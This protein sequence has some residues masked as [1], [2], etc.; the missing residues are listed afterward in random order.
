MK[1]RER[2]FKK[3]SSYNSVSV[4]R[5]KVNSYLLSQYNISDAW[6]CDYYLPHRE[7]SYDKILD[8]V[9]FGDFLRKFLQGGLWPFDQYRFWVLSEAS[10]K[11]MTDFI[12]IPKD[13]V[14]VI[15]RYE[16]FSKGDLKEPFNLKKIKKIYSVGQLRSEKN[17]F[18]SLWLVYFL[19]QEHHLQIEF[20]IVGDFYLG[21][22]YAEDDR[23]IFKE[24]VLSLINDLDWKIKPIFHGPIENFSWEKSSNDYAFLNLSTYF[25]EDF[26]L[27]QASSQEHNW[28]SIVSQW[29]GLLD[30]EGD[31][32]AQIPFQIIGNSGD[33]ILVSKIRGKTLAHYLINE[34]NEKIVIQ[35]SIAKMPSP[36]TDSEL[37]VIRKKFIK[38]WGPSVYHV[39]N[40]INLVLD[41][42]KGVS[43]HESYQEIFSQSKNEFKKVVMINELDD[44][45]NDMPDRVSK[46]KIDHE[47]SLIQ[48]KD[49]RFKEILNKS[50]SAKEIYIPKEL[51]QSKIFQIFYQIAKDR[52][53]EF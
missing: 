14:S 1:K 34:K 47:F 50:L 45:I 21:D 4:L 26:S 30:I 15:P 28:Y 49:L 5:E 12:G 24:K 20:N 46:L 39:F 13:C 40:N 35:K 32:F 22:D 51:A 10:K 43:F 9:F 2:F 27:A 23:L 33:S 17:I 16:L 42:Q 53:R 38:K 31:S 19:Q 36:L 29:G 11:V 25:H 37:H 18:L 52:I 3:D 44:E 7:D 8:V 6:F 41:S 48:I